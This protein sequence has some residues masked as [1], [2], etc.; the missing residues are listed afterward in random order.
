MCLKEQQRKLCNE[1]KKRTKWLR[2][3]LNEAKGW[4]FSGLLLAFILFWVCCISKTIPKL[5]YSVLDPYP[6]LYFTY[7]SI[8]LATLGSCGVNAPPAQAGGFD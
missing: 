7:S 4:I 5:A 3:F 2:A 1:C 8:C 6:F